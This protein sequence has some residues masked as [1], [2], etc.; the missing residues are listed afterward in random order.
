MLI[1]KS[2]YSAMN[3]PRNKT[4]CCLY[5]FSSANCH[6][7]NI[8]TPNIALH[9]ITGIE[10]H[11]TIGAAQ[12]CHPSVENASENALPISHNEMPIVKFNGSLNVL[13][14]FLLLTLK[15]QCILLCVI[16]LNETYNFLRIFL[17]YTFVCQI[18]ILRSLYN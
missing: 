14:C 7:Q 4:L 13:Y 16:C 5:S 10:F 3:G 12:Q 2:N 11:F 15:Q 17:V 1:F 6:S 8:L 9:R 18:G